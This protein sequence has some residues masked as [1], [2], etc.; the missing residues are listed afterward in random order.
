MGCCRIYQEIRLLKIFCS[1]E[2]EIENEVNTSL[3][4]PKTLVTFLKIEIS[5]LIKQSTFYN[6]KIF[7]RSINISQKSQ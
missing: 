2:Q 3:V 5:V 4:T 1:E 7:K 6:N